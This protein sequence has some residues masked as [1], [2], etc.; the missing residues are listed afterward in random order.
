ME[1]VF[2]FFFWFK[3]LSGKWGTAP[4][5]YV[6]VYTELY[7]SHHALFYRNST[8]CMKSL[9]T[10]Q[11]TDSVNYTEE[12]LRLSQSA[13]KVL[14]HQVKIGGCLKSWKWLSTC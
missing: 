1:V 3:N 12:A 9:G 4:T 2:K 8:W 5:G 6:N 7:Y 11:I 13:I 10:Q 14:I